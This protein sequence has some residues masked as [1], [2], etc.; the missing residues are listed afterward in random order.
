MRLRDR[1]IAFKEGFWRVVIPCC[2]G[3]VDPEMAEE[4]IWQLRRRQSGLACDRSR[5][6]KPLGILSPRFCRGK[7]AG[8]KYRQHQPLN[9]RAPGDGAKGWT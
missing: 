8:Q 4:S 5:R 2:D 3:A 7:S 9:G 6:P 1:D